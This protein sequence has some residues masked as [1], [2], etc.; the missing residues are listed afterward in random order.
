MKELEF[1]RSALQLQSELQ[2]LKIEL[3]SLKA[4]MAKSK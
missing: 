4:Q 1:A 2:S 3:Q